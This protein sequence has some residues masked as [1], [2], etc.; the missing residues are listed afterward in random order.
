MDTNAQKV[1]TK[2]MNAKETG[3]QINFAENIRKSSVVQ[4]TLV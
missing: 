4:E 3:F 1:K 2:L